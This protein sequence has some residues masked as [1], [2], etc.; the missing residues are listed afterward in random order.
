MN[1]TNEYREQAQE[2]ARF[3]FHGDPLPTIGGTVCV[4]VQSNPEAAL[5]GYI[6]AA[7]SSRDSEIREVLEGLITCT[8]DEGNGPELHWCPFGED[9]DMECGPSCVAA[10]E[11]YTKAG[12]SL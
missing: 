6:E 1:P 12:G 8:L 11:L 10:R 2:I 9:S 3:F 4:S 5:A 7:L